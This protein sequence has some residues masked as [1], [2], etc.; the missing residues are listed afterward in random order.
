MTAPR[1]LVVSQGTHDFW[2]QIAMAYHALGCRVA[3]VSHRPGLAL[4]L[5]ARGETYDAVLTNQEAINHLALTLRDNRTVDWPRTFRCFVMVQYHDVIR[6]LPTLQQ[7]SVIFGWSAIPFVYQA[8]C[9]RTADFLRRTGLHANM[10]YAPTPFVFGRSIEVTQSKTDNYVADVAE[11]QRPEPAFAAQPYTPLSAPDI[12]YCATCVPVK[13]IVLR[14]DGPL[15]TIPEFIAALDAHT[16]RGRV[17]DRLSFIEDLL[18]RGVLGPQHIA[19]A[20]AAEYLFN[21]GIVVV[22]D[23]RKTYVRALRAKFGS[24]FD[25]FGLDWDRIGIDSI[26]VE[27]AAAP[28]RYNNALVSIDLGSQFID[29]SFYQR[30]IQ[31]MESGGRLLQLGQIDR[32]DAYGPFA[33]AVCFDD[34]G[35]LMARLDAALGDPD[36]FRSW[37][38]GFRRHLEARFHPDAVCPPVLRHLG[39]AA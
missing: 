29:L 19:D 26:P 11:V 25:L 22:Q 16:R 35:G 30:T 6:E 39:L 33:D 8:V 37:Q 36:G 10:V 24:R 12:L 17:L 20:T 34:V 38:T 32:D 4:E 1:I 3:L 14:P 23:I 28:Q 13:Q 5:A 18:E 7:A 21:Y 31:I 9:R 15:A 2:Q 27:R